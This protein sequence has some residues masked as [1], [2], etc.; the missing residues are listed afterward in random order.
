[1]ATA[2]PVPSTARHGNV[3][4]SPTTPPVDETAVFLTRFA[5]GAW[6]TIPQDAATVNPDLLALI[7]GCPAWGDED[8]EVWVA[9]RPETE[10]T[11][12]FL[13]R[14][15]LFR[16]LI[17]D[18]PGW[19]LARQMWNRDTNPLARACLLCEAGLWD[20]RE[21]WE[22]PGFAAQALEAIQA[23]VARGLGALHGQHLPRSTWWVRE[24]LLGHIDWARGARHWAPRTWM[25]LLRCVTEGMRSPEIRR[26]LDAY[27]ASGAAAMPMDILSDLLA[28]AHAEVRLWAQ[29]EIARHGGER[30]GTGA[31]AGEGLGEPEGVKQRPHPSGTR[32]LL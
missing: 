22:D 3:E 17:D 23:L 15:T 30:P 25:D 6:R 11:P 21:W 13:A 4:P 1:M 31:N 10:W 29:C 32:S 2:P 27:A 14:L 9:D 7:Q 16:E 19:P 18:G 8:T 12:I 20:G 26:C 28:H 24:F 5:S